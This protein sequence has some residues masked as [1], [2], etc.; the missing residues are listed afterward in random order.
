MTTIK[1]NDLQRGFKRFDPP[2]DAGKLLDKKSSARFWSK[3]GIG[4]PDECWNWLASKQQFGY[5]VFWL[6]PRRLGAH[7]VSYIDCNGPIPDGMLVRHR[8]DN[9]SCCNPLHLEVGTQK[10]NLRDAVDRGRLDRGKYHRERWRSLII[11]AA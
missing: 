6:S 2:E 1:N 9:P 4:M 10:Q 8:C 3:V 7:C 11:K 5:G